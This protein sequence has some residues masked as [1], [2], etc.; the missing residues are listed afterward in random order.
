MQDDALKETF[1]GKLEYDEIG[2]IINQAIKAGLEEK[3][4]INIDF[5]YNTNS[6]LID[7][8]EVKEN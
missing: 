6:V 3:I 2:V 5:H 4:N 7:I 8:K 1:T